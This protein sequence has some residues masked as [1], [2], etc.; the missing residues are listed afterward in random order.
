MASE[1][2][3]TR[4]RIEITEVRDVVLTEIVSQNGEFMRS[5]RI[6]GEPGGPTDWPVL[7]VQIRSATR[8]DIEITTPELGF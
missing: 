1:I 7:E 5:I 2:K 6:Y 4:Q 3:S 8:S